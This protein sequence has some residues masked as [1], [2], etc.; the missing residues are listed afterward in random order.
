MGKEEGVECGKKKEWSVERRRSGVWKEEGVEWGKKK[1][2]SVERRRSGVGKEE[3]VEWVK[4][5]EWSGERRTS[6]VEWG[7]I[8]LY[9]IL[10][11]QPVLPFECILREA[12]CEDLREMNIYNIKR[13]NSIL[14]LFA[15]YCLKI[16]TSTRCS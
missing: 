15:I 14:F 3:G 8:L 16:A 2:W 1:E 5:N 9:P 6:G 7:I 11:C 10:F 12:K 4:K 13:S